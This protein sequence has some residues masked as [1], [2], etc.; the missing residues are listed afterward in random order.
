MAVAKTG[1]ELVD[2]RLVR[3]LG[4]AEPPS[5]TNRIGKGLAQMDRSEHLLD[6]IDSLDTP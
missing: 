2:P 6:Q 4:V 3:L 5:R 1:A